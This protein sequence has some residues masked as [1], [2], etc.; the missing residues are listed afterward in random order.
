MIMQAK[1]ADTADEKIDRNVAL[2]ESRMPP[3]AHARAATT[4]APVAT[5]TVTA[6]VA[7]SPASKQPTVTA[8]LTPANTTPAA[9]ATTRAHI[10]APAAASAAGAPRVLG[11]DVV[12]QSVPVDPLAGPTA[13]KGKHARP[14][15]AK[16][17][18]ADVDKAKT[19][20]LRM[21][22]DAS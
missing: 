13:K 3:A 1:A 19:P 21:S 16:P 9:S 6:P 4:P 5:Q 2:V 7:A 10:A 22:A 20:A 11:K 15:Q 12:M 18:V 17:A 14:A 8:S